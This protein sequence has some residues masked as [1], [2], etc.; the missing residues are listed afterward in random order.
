MPDAPPYRLVRPS[1][2]RGGRRGPRGTARPLRASARDR[3]RRRLDG[4]PPRASCTRFLD[5]NGIPAGAAFR[6]QDALDN[7]NPAVRRRRRH[8]PQPEARRAGARGRPPARRRAAAGRGDDLRVHAAR[9]AEAAPDARARPPG[10]RGAR[11]RVPGRPADPG[12]ARAVR[13]R[14]R[15][16]ARRRALAANGRRRHGPTSRHGSSTRRSP[17]D[18]DLGELHRPHARARPGRDRHATAPATT[19]SGSTASG[20]STTTPPS[21]RR[22]AA[23]WATGSP[24]RSRRSSCQPARTVRLLLGR[25]RLP[26]ARPG[27]RDRR[28]V[29]RC[30][31]SWS[32]STTACTARSGCTRSGASRDGSWAPS[33]STPT[34]PRTP[35]RSEPT[36]RR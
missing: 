3:R 16:P 23:P 8:R 18:V 36:A 5:A 10:S 33:S 17:G 7:D 1:A 34:S 21:S 19:P 30:R 27:A 9:R 22:R 20:A 15:R 11:A 25:R 26:D 29:R 24:L 35:A 31:S 12:R 2:R 14:G 32:W 28:P 6:R 4:R 13:R